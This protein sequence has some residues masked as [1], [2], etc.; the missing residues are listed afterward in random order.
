MLRLPPRKDAS[1]LTAA[2]LHDFAGDPMDAEEGAREAACG[3]GGMVRHC[4]N[5]DEAMCARMSIVCPVASTWPRMDGSRTDKIKKLVCDAGKTED[6]RHVL[7][8]FI[9]SKFIFPRPEDRIRWKPSERRD[10]GHSPI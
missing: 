9:G 1:A 3:G 7:V 5:Y 4:E 2:L 10:V 8:E 6:E